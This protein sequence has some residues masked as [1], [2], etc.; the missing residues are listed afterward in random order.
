MALAVSCTW[1]IPPG[2]CLATAIS[3]ELHDSQHVYQERRICTGH[4]MR[5]ALERRV[6]RS[7]RSV[8]GGNVVSPDRLRREVA[9]SLLMMRP[10]PRGHSTGDAQDREFECVMKDH[11]SAGAR[12]KLRHR[13]RDKR[14]EKDSA[15]LSLETSSPERPPELSRRNTRGGCKARTVHCR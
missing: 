7:P 13:C 9:L 3:H 8:D 12:R 10:D 6:R 4:V 14:E 5:L 15:P 2:C 11:P 1:E